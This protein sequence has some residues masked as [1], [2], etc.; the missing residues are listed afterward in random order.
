MKIVITTV[1]GKDCQC[2]LLTC[3]RPARYLFSAYCS[4][5]ELVSPLIYTSCHEHKTT[6]AANVMTDV[7]GPY[8]PPNFVERPTVK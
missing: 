4:A 3:S 5:P 8:T 1:E 6:V 7:Y 2:G